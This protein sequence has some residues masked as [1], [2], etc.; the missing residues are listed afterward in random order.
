MDRALKLDT[1]ARGDIP[2]IVGP[3][4]RTREAREVPFASH[5]LHELAQ[6][7]LSVKESI[8]FDPQQLQC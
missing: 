6:E 1:I 2:A 7:G 8:G 4:A 3:N 5:R